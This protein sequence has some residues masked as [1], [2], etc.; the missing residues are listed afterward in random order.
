MDTPKS[1]RS[2][3]SLPRAPSSLRRLSIRPDLRLNTL[4]SQAAI[5]SRRQSFTSVAS[6]HI[7]HT[8]LKS[9]IRPVAIQ[10][11]PSI[12]ALNLPDA[13]TKNNTEVLVELD[14]IPGPPDGGWGW[15]ICLAC[16]MG[17]FVGDGIAYTFGVLIKP[18]A[19]YFNAPFSQVSIIGSV[20]GTMAFAWGPL[21][22]FLVNR[23]G[24]RPVC[25]A[26][27]LMCGTGFAL[28]SLLATNVSSMIA[29][30][31]FMAGSGLGLMYVPTIISVNYYFDKKRSIANG[32]S[33]S[34]SC[35]GGLV[36]APALNVVVQT[37]GWKVAML[38]LAGLAS[39][40]VVE[41]SLLRP[42]ELVLNEEE[43]DNF[44]DEE[45]KKIEVPHLAVQESPF[46]RGSF[47][48]KRNSFVGSMVTDN[49]NSLDV[50]GGGAAKLSLRP[51][52]RGS[53]AIINPM[54]I[55]DSFLQSSTSKFQ[56]RSDT[57]SLHPALEVDDQS[58]IDQSFLGCVVSALNLKW[59]TDPIFLLMIAKVFLSTMGEYTPH[60]YLPY[61]ASHVPQGTDEEGNPIYPSTNQGAFLVS[62][63]NI[64]NMAGR[65]LM[66]A[67][68]DLPWVSSIVVFNVTTI[69]TSMAM[70]A[71]L[72]VSDYWA[73]CTVSVIYGFSMSCVS[74]QISVVLA[75]L[76]GIDA[77]SSTF[78]LL[79]FFRGAAFSV[80]W[81][82]GG[83]VYEVFGSRKAIFILGAVELLSSGIIGVI[84]HVAHRVKIERAKAVPDIK[85]AKTPTLKIGDNK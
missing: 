56:D 7:S 51:A 58:D 31:G 64:G 26:G 63:V 84:M 37:Y 46:R 34:G 62:I 45:P 17:N 80:A 79:C 83:V 20:T 40:I 5:G 41:G 6:S 48:S 35:V 16:F 4:Q 8:S 77:L 19:E 12:C 71:F 18:L 33:L 70:V 69:T 25:I 22:S 65:I 67:L 81:P 21:S 55:N 68:V 59:F 47:M 66:G 76:F 50:Y 72:F 36:L 23:F 32:L 54:D 29:L 52:R 60:C 75:E 28:S 27:G 74:S 39:L 61:Y 11:K 13:V 38:V 42:L 10:R 44:D 30:Y 3:R 49:S 53:Q 82:L 57:V 9:H 73:F 2:M 78:G 1:T 24:S 43:E 14:E 85:Y 15:V